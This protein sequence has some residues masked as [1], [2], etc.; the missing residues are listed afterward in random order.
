MD[1]IIKLE[2]DEEEVCSAQLSDLIERAKAGDD[3]LV[4]FI[5]S[6]WDGE[7]FEDIVEKVETEGS[8]WYV[9]WMDG[10]RAFMRSDNI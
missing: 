2:S 6:L 7:S 3:N 9:W 8:T 10:V 5:R 1:D 4:P